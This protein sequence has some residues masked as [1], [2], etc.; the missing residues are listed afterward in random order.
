MSKKKF[1]QET[2]AVLM[3]NPK[4]LEQE[5]EKW[6]SLAIG[7]AERLWK[8]LDELGYG[9]RAEADPKAKRNWYSELQDQERFDRSWAKYGREGG[10]NEAAKAWIAL[11]EKEKTHIEYSIPKYL[12]QLGST[13]K[14]KAHFSTWLNDRRWESFEIKQQTRA[15]GVDERAQEIAGLQRLISM[16]RDENTKQAFQAQ[17]DR[18]TN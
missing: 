11:T 10:R 15:S 3:N 7:W 6:P 2:S 12:E 14:A 4:I 5:P 17:L 13:G 1:I 16:A 8:R 9:D 18:L